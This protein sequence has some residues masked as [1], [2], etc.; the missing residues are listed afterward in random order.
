LRG[1]IKGVSLRGPMKGV[2]FSCPSPWCGFLG[3]ADCKAATLNP[4][5]SLEGDDDDDDED[6]GGDDVGDVLSGSLG[7]CGNGAFA[8]A[9][10]TFDFDFEDDGFFA[11]GV[12]LGG[13]TT[14]VSKKLMDSNNASASIP[15]VLLLVEGGDCASGIG[16]AANDDDG[17]AAAAGGLGFGF[18][19]GFA[20]FWICLEPFGD[21]LS[22]AFNGGA[23]VVGGVVA[24][25]MCAA[26]EEEEGIVAAI[27]EGKFGEVKMGALCF[28]SSS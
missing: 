19:F 23:A 15:L 3:F 25:G 1:P 14:A 13:V 28:A 22:F 18:G 24:T 26:G 16:W 12:G 11:T 17:C 8:S 4:D 21:S 5:K 10:T 27:G 6:L 20:A 9:S 7:R 2:S